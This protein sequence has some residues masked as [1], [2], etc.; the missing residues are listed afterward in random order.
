MEIHNVSEDIVFSS[1]E[2]IFATIKES[3]NTG[4]LCLCDQCKLDTICYTLNRVKP[5]Y[6]VSNRGMT[7]IEQDWTEKQQT[8]A[9]I[10]ALIS[11]GVVLVNHNQRPTCSHSEDEV[12]V[13]TILAE[14]AFSIP[15]IIGRLFDGETFDPL[16]G[17]T[18]EL[19]S[20]G[21]IVPMRNQNWQNPFT[22][23]A[24]TPGSFTFW[25]APVPADA[26]GVHRTFGYSLKIESTQYE[27][28]T[29][30]FKVPAISSSQFSHNTLSLD[31]TFKLPDLYL[32]PPGEAEQNG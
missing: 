28:M 30:F 5:L 31:R 12:I 32:F 27:T 26:P 11:K 14:A 17:V 23:I 3:G 10:A 9:D 1:V 29:H 21:E 22:L 7:R 25:P 2:K 15:T 16:S 13:S 6:I 19:R 18:V 4:G 24:N 8:A 20:G